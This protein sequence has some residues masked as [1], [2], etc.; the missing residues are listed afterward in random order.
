MRKRWIPFHDGAHTPPKEAAGI[1]QRPGVG[2]L[3]LIHYSQNR[4]AQ[5]LAEARAVFSNTELAKE[6]STLEI[7]ATR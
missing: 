2:R 1:A 6:G 3:V 5:V 7:S 4:A